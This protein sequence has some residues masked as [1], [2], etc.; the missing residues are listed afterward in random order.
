MTRSLEMTVSTED[1]GTG[2]S[3]ILESHGFSEPEILEVI[4]RTA[5][6]IIQRGMR[7]S[8][9]AAE[10]F[11]GM[12]HDQTCAQLALQSRLTLIS[13]ITEMDLVDSAGVAI[14]L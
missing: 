11:A 4:T 5:E 14:E 8:P 12:S 2:A 10:Q 7:D 9:E 1:D 13:M 3:I 6:S